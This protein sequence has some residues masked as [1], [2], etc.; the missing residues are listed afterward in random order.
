MMSIGLALSGCS[1]FSRLALSGP[2]VA[3]VVDQVIGDLLIPAVELSDAVARRVLAAQRIIFAESLSGNAP[4]LSGGRGGCIGG[5]GLGEVPPAALFGAAVVDAR[6]GFDDDAPDDFSGTDLEYRQSS[7][8][9]SP[10]RCR[11]RRDFSSRS[12]ADLVLRLAR[13]TSLRCWCG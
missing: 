1:T 6:V 11:R 13:R 2:S 12:E 10:V 7:T 4:W 9:L 3:Q 5:I 8:C